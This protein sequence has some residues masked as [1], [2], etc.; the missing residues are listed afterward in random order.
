MSEPALVPDR[1]LRDPQGRR[2]RRTPQHPAQGPRGRLPPRRL[3]REGA[4]LLRG[5]G[6]AAD[7]RPRV[8]PA[9]SRPS[10]ASTSSSSPPTRTHR[11]RSTACRRC[12][13][14][15]MTS[16]LTFETVVTDPTDTAVIL[17]TSGT[18][19][20]PKGAELTHANMTLNA[21][22]TLQLHGKPGRGLGHPPADAAAVPLVRPDRADERRL[23]DGRHAGAAAALRRQG[24]PR[25]D[26]VAG[27][28]LLRRRTDDVL[29]AARRPGRLGRRGADR[30]QPAGLRRGGVVAAGRDHPRVQE[31]V[32][33]RHQGGLRAVRDVAGG[34]LQ[35]ARPRVEARLDRHADLG[36]RGQA[37]RRRLDRRSRATTRSARSPSA[38]TTS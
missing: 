20:Q 29:G 16:P 9:S 7:R 2:R 28:H 17:Y 8:M 19:G 4:L 26:A 30:R 3:R 36:R 5:H 32:R 10:R 6:R 21:M 37:D 22:S 34:D 33:R 25:P 38:A 18:T 15:S 12:A 27:H 24:G 1:L 11:R 14:R 23:R 35:P 13:R 31:A